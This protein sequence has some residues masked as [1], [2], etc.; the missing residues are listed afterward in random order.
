MEKKN[1]IF[2]WLW[3][4]IIALLTVAAVRHFHIKNFNVIKEGVLYTCGQPRGMDYTRLLY[5]YHITTFINLRIV[6]EHREENWHQEEVE[7]MKSSG[8]KYIELPISKRTPINEIA[9][10]EQFRMFMDVMNDKS[11]YPV[12][13]HDS[14]GRDR[15]SYFTAIWMLKSGGFGLEETVTKVEKLQKKPLDEKEMAFLRT[16]AN[17]Q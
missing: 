2:F 8:V 3:P 4:V 7:W 6:G 17:R 5:K 12:L 9:D 11:N 10:T 13:V 15:V 16:I 14:S 1:S